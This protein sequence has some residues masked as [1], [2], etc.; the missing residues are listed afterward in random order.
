MPALPVSVAELTPA[1]TLEPTEVIPPPRDYSDR[2]V[3]VD[4]FRA[5]ESSSSKPDR[6]WARIPDRPLNERPALDRE[7]VVQRL[8]D[9]DF[10][11]AIL[12][13]PAYEE[14]SDGQRPLVLQ[15]ALLASL[16]L[17][18]GFGLGYVYR[19]RVAAAA[20]QTAAVTSPV[21]VYSSG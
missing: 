17:M 4:E 11:S 13:P 15:G 19:D 6:A 3:A 1:A 14:S 8:K 10:D 18:L 16:C 12:P 7:P 5:R 9:E 20:A 21:G 2:V